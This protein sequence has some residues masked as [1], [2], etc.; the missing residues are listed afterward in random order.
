MRVC[1]WCLVVFVCH[2]CDLLCGAVGFAVVLTVFDVIVW[3]VC[4]L[5][6]DSVWCVCVC[7]MSCVLSVRCFFCVG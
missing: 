7:V 2:V 5:V 4:A 3:Y 6:C 1:V